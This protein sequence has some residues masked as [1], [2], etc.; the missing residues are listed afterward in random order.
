[1][2]SMKAVTEKTIKNCYSECS[3]YSEVLSSEK[4]QATDNNMD[5]RKVYAFLKQFTIH[6]NL[7]TICEKP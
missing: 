7:K 5:T 2:H 6:N 3:F 4:L 1:M